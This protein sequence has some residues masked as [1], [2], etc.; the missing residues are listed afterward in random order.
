MSQE[1]KLRIRG[2]FSHSNDL[3]AVPDGALSKADNIVIDRDDLS[4][5]W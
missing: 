2:L 4:G 1:L 5:K 3:S